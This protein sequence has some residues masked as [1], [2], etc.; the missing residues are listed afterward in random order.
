MKKPSRLELVRRGK[1]LTLKQLAEKVG[2]GEGLVAQVEGKHRRAYPKLR[3]ELAKVLGVDE[4]RLF[5]EEGFVK[6]LRR[7]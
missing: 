4:Q 7:R 6:T 2:V 5:D 3:T 1:A